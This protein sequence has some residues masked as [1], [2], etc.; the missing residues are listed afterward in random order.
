MK[1]KKNAVNWFEIA[2]TDFDR[3]KKFYDTILGTSLTEVPVEGCR[4]GMFPF[5]MAN[6]IGGSI[7]LMAEMKPGPGGTL[8]YL[9]VE[10]EL[11]AVIARIVTAG[12]AILR[13]RFAIG[14][15]GFISII[16]DT[17]GNVVG[18]HSMT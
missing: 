13:P 8:V 16:Q 7:S 3:A 1:P 17:E 5:D 11:D 9:N 2:V 6:G 18:L 4:M 15:H 12:G 10:G 14:E